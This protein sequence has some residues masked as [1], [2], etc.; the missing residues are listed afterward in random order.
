MITLTAL[1]LL[2][3]SKIR[4]PHGTPFNQVLN[5]R[6]GRPVLDTYRLYEKIDLKVL[7]L[8]SDLKFL[9]TCKQHGIIPKFIFFKTYNAKFKRTKLYKS[10]LSQLLSFEIK[11]KQKEHRIASRRRSHLTSELK[12][13]ITFQ[14]DFCYVI[15]KAA[16]FNKSKID[17]KTT[18]HQR[19]L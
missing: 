12:N 10:W 18:Q 4:F 13:T 15:D 16:Q 1:V 17:I 11:E 8:E 14:P 5:Q 7:T 2:F 19:K 9:I 3:I 6:Y